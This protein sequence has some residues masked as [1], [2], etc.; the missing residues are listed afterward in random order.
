MQAPA[1]ALRLAR[2]FTLW[3]AVL[4][5]AGCGSLI[6]QTVGLRTDWPDG[7]PRQVELAQVPFFP[8]NEYQCGPAAL[9]TAMNFS[10]GSVSPEA[11]VAEVWLPS[12]RGSLQ[13][14]MLAAPRRHGLVSYRIEPRYADL[15]REVAAGNPVVVLQDVGMMLPEWHYAVVN[16]FDYESGTILLRS[17]LQ[18]RQEMPFSYFERTWLAGSYWA[19]VVTAPDRIAATATEERWLEAL[20][21]LARGGNADAAVKGY[22]AALARWPDSLPAA[23][24]LA[25]Q[26]HARG[27]LDEA[28]GVLRT[29]LK[30]FPQSVILLNNLAQTLSDQGRNREALALIRQAEDPKSPFAGEVR[31]TRQLIEGRLRRP[32][33]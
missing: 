14:E 2:R 10:G 18:A 8:Q 20:L 30:R 28:T 26:L 24:G 5:L 27:S 11:L 13:V 33:G 7:V 3:A 25:N 6:P 1:I 21:G 29:A 19:M 15:L 4:L 22:R 12:R 17:G 31:A 23:V 32:G 9:A 16:G